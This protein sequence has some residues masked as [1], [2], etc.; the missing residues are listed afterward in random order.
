MKKYLIVALVLFGCNN[1][2]TK[3]NSEYLAAIEDHQTSSY[4]FPK[5]YY[6]CFNFSDI[7]LSEFDLDKVVGRINKNHLQDVWYKKRSSMC[8]APGSQIGLTYIVQPELLVRVSE[9]DSQLLNLGF[10]ETPTPKIA[11]CAYQVLHYK[12]Y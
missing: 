3:P 6:Y 1:E 9:Q 4:S 2:V 8:I 11:D 10:V 5:G 7:A 12:Y